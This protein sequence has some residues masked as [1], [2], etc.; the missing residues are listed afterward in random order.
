MLDLFSEGGKNPQGSAEEALGLELLILAA[1]GE[2]SDA[3]SAPLGETGAAH[4]APR[5]WRLCAEDLALS[6]CILT[7]NVVKYESWAVGKT[8][9][10]VIKITSEIEAL[11]VQGLIF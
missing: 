5:L 6:P 9:P 10:K 3:P 11:A 7:R 4:S 8:M 2:N 1:R